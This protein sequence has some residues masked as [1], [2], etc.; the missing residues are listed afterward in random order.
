M[1]EV[2]NSSVSTEVMSWNRRELAAPESRAPLLLSRMACSSPASRLIRITLKALQQNFRRVIANLTEARTK[3]GMYAACKGAGAVL[4]LTRMACCSLA[5]KLIRITLKAL[6][7]IF[8]S[9][10]I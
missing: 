7:H 4:L 3:R 5:S 8:R 10:G 1:E 2:V 6:H 9:S